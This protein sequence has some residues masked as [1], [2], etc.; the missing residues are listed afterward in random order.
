MVCPFVLG[1]QVSFAKLASGTKSDRDP[2]ADIPDA[3]LF[4][5]QQ[6]YTLA[7]SAPGQVYCALINCMFRL[8]HI[9]ALEQISGKIRSE[10][11]AD[12]NAHLQIYLV[13]LL[14]PPPW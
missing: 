2:F 11:P 13:V 8:Y 12:V 14:L 1:Y 10:L 4:L 7:S 5:A 9:L 3:R 6:L